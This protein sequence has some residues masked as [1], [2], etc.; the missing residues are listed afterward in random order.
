[1]YGKGPKKDQMAK[2][3]QNYEK[4]MAGVTKGKKRP[5]KGMTKAR[6]GR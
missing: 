6:R 5:A 3:K 2:A 1:M 4:R